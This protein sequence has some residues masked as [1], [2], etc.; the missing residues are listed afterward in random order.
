MSFTVGVGY[1]LE[2]RH[3]VVRV[4]NALKTQPS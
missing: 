4:L 2:F 3:S 1:I